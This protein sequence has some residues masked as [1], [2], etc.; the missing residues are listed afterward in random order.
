MR[1]TSMARPPLYE[2]EPGSPSAVSAAENG[3]FFLPYA[4]EMKK[5]VKRAVLGTTGGWRDAT[6]MREAVRSGDIDCVG[7]GRV[8]LV[9]PDFP[10]RSIEGSVEK[11]KLEVEQVEDLYQHPYGGLLIFYCAIQYSIWMVAE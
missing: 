4:R 1:N 8:L 3:S 7:L 9:W 11:A 10:R 2:F 5:F 6:K